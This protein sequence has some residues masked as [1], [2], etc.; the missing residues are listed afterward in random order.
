MRSE[1][2]LQISPGQCRLVLMHDIK[3]EIGVM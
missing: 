1:V 3:R 2:A